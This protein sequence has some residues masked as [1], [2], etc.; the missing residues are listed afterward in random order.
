[1]KPAI[2]EVTGLSVSL[3]AGADRP[4]AVANAS[5]ELRRGEILCGRG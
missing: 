5:F 3:P 2:L 1:M 4:Y